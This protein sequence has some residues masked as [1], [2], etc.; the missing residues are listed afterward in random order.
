M[1]YLTRSSPGVSVH[2]TCGPDAEDW[3]EYHDALGGPEWALDVG[4]ECNTALE[5]AQELE[6]D[7][8][9]AGVT[10]CA[11]AALRSLV[12]RVAEFE[13]LQTEKP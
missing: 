4:E 5:V 10:S 8:Q 12:R 13:D 9:D 2:A 7:A 11:A 3:Y 1:R 6:L